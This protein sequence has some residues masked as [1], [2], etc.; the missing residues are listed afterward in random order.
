MRGEIH[1]EH[2]SFVSFGSNRCIG[3]YPLQLFVHEFSPSMAQLHYDKRI[4]KLKSLARAI[5]A[6]V[7]AFDGQHKS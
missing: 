3:Q 4:E 7:V 1:A 2:F 6:N 5:V